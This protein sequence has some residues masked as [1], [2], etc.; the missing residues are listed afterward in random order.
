MRLTVLGLR[1]QLSRPRL[2]LLRL[3][4]RGR[5]FRLLL[6]FG[7]GRCPALQRYVGLDRR[8]RDPAR[9][10]A[11]R[12]HARRV[13][14]T[15]WCAGTPRTART[16]RC[17]CTRPA[18]A[19]DRLAPRTAR[20]AA[21]DDV[22]TFYDLQPGTSRSARSRSPWTGSTTRSRRTACG[23]STAAGCC[24][25]SADTAPCE[26]LLRLAQGAD[27]FLCEASY[28]DGVDNPPDLH[29]TGREAGE[30]AAKAGVGRLVLT[31]LVAA[32]GSEA[33]T[34][35][36]PRPAFAGPIEVVRAGA[37]LRRLTARRRCRRFAV[38]VRR[39]VSGRSCCR[40]GAAVTLGHAGRDR[41]R[42]L[43]ARR[44]RRGPLRRPGRRAPGPTGPP[45]AGHRARAAPAARQRS[46][47]ALPYPVVR[48]PSRA[49]ARLP[50]A[51]GSALPSRPA[52]RRRCADHRA[53]VVH[54]ASPFVLGAR[55]RGRRRPARPAGG[56]RLPDR[57]A[58]LRPGVPAGLR[59]RRP[60][61]AG[62][63]G[64]TTRADRTLA[65]S[66]AAAADLRRARRAA[67][68][69]VAARA[70]TP[71]AS[72]PASAARRCAGALA[73]GRR[74]DRRLRRPAGRRRS[75]STCWPR[76]PSCP[77]CGWWWSATGRPRR[78]LR[79]ALPGAVFLGARH[80]R[81]AGPALRQPRRVRAHRTAS[82]PS[83]RPCRRRMA[84]GVPV[85]APAAGGP[86]DL[87]EPRA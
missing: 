23:W 53:D 1:R 71:S 10:P 52:G 47:A 33:Q 21:V 26:A 32:W 74:G 79:R 29:L 19:P 65:P 87:V 66:T 12:P 30:V 49:A 64:S 62:C 24:A 73:P 15:S 75:G 25:Y 50:A 41:D 67:G 34:L 59:A 46:P 7:T 16:R 78:Q 31:H 81:R 27:L 5:R 38:L 37:T 43:P 61:G 22:Y 9:P 40:A 6:D 51:S 85:V 86:L 48:V 45:A 44:Q 39:P 82:R 28:L 13:L 55:G 83:A 63:A 42:V 84:S 56:R 18:G 3:P 76:S 77:A 2:A 57:R 80:G 60:P 72:T 54:L 69:A 8:R 35:R 17:R 20:R 14:A 36:R 70:W 58:R 4:G 68:L 11:L